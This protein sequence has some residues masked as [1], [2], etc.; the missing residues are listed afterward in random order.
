L[1][2]D[3][4]ATIAAAALFA[5]ATAGAQ[6]IDD[7]TAATFARAV[8][9]ARARL[10]ADGGRLWRTRLDTLAWLG[11][12]G[13]AIVLSDDP[14]QPGYERRPDGLWGGP[15][16]DGIAPANTS[17]N[18]AGRRWAMVVLPLTTDTL[19][20]T[21]LLIHEASHVAQPSALP[22]PAYREGGP[23]AAL[24]DGPEGREWLRLE[25]AALASALEATTSDA[26]HRAASDAL[27]F[28]ARRYLA[29]SEDEVQ[30]E[31]VLDVTEGLPEYTAWTLVGAPRADFARHIRQ[32]AANTPSFVRSFPYYTGPAYAML[33]DAEPATSWRTRL[34]TIPNLQRIVAGT[35]RGVPAAV[36]AML[37]GDSAGAAEIRRLAEAAGPRYGLDTVRVTER[38]RWTERERQI[39]ALRARFVSGPLVRLRPGMLQIS[40][41]ERRQTSLGVDG[42][43]MGGFTWRGTNGAELTAPDGVLVTSDWTELRVPRD[44]ATF[45]SGALSEKR[46]WQGNG[47]S[48]T[49]PAGWDITV[50]GANIVIKAPPR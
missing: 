16:P 49:L 44:A 6:T 20:A 42:T 18:W 38:T 4:R 24:L 23:G 33:L 35:V 22:Q 31:R 40:F 43:V 21:R 47:W 1:D 32:R 12:R 30:R 3:V 14:R 37:V 10:A 9:A 48:L 19:A 5:A 17:V 45:T 8:H 27:V 50:D 13:R 29:A 2:E 15:L 7:S 26:R 39:A 11:V 41:D 28:R 25:W 34:T 36:S 46:T